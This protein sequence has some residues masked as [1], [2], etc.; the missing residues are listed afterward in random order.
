M[1][2]VTAIPDATSGAAVGTR[3][4]HLLLTL[5]GDFWYHRSESLPSTAL[6]RLLA[7][8]GVTEPNARAAISRLARKDLLVATRQGRRTAYALSETGHATLVEGTRRIF[9]FGNDPQPWDGRWTMVAFSVPE[10]NR[11]LRSTL[12]TRLRWLG[13]TALFDGVWTAPGDHSAEAGALLAEL[14]LTTATIVV[15][16]ACGPA[17]GDPARAWDLQGLSDRYTAFLAD[18]GDIAE[19]VHAGEVS[20]TEA[21]VRRTTLIDVWRTFP[22]LDPELP[23]ELLPA[24]W[25]ARRA[26]ELFTDVYDALGPRATRRFR[27]LVAVDDPAAAPLARHHT[28]T[29]ALSEA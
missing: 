22:A 1:S 28:S 7:E 23:V 4:Q 15:G 21:L 13:F 26:R 12:R 18:F 3:P 10:E 16:T 17:E 25:P 29:E 20:D 19:R 5:L 14:S 2:E 8:F 24:D 27:E 6:V 9:R 11:P